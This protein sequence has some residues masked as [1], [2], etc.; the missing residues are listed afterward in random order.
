MRI[1]VLWSYP[2]VVISTG[3][4]Q[5]ELRALLTSEPPSTEFEQSPYDGLI[6][7][8]ILE[9][10]AAL[11]SQLLAAGAAAAGGGAAPAAGAAAAAAGAASGAAD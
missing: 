8:A 2:F 5:D 11:V 9:E 6:A 10:K 7:A 3:D 4:V 1:G